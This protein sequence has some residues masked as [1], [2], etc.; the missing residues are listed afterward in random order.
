MEIWKTIPEFEMYSV[1]NKGQVRND[2]RNRILNLFPVG[3]YLMV[4]LS[5][6]GK[7]KLLYV[8]RLVG[9]VFV[10]NPNMYPEINH[11]NGKKDD[12]NSENLEWVTR[13][14]NIKHAYAINLMKPMQ[15]ESSAM[16]KLTDA[17]VNKIREL[18]ASGIILR[19]LSDRFGVA[20]SVISN[21]SNYKAWK[22]L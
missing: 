6:N 5:S 22:H 16:S 2:L 1:S 7:K 3:G 8:H 15:G 21:V 14:E 11:K 19:E 20:K 18:R 12:N 17:D 9:L 13:S 10:D 4:N